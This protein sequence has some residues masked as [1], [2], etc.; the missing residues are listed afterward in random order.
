MRH[1]SWSLALVLAAVTV[2]G[3][4]GDL[5]T[6]MSESVAAQRTDGRQARTLD[7]ACDYARD[8]DWA[9]ATHLLQ[10][11]LDLQEDRLVPLKI[12]VEV[13]EVT[14]LVS[15]RKRADWLVG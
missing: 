11:V 8:Q 9:K 5:E 4:W 12:N 6:K 14:I 2:G 13:A 1:S 7:A 3:S 10:K 15:A